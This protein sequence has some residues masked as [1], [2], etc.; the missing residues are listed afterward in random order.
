M[1]LFSLSYSGRKIRTARQARLRLQ[2]Q[3]IIEG[4]MLASDVHTMPEE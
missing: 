4:T 1:L 2:Q 3:W